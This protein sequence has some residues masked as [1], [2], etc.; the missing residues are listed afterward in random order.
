[1][2]RSATTVFEPRLSGSNMQMVTYYTACR[3]DAATLHLL[4]LENATWPKT[5]WNDM[6]KEFVS[7]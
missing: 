5:W 7:E 3:I 2:F 4:S 6:K 1:M